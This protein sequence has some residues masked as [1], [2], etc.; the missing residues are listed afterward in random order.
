MLDALFALRE[1]SEYTESA[2]LQVRTKLAA[3][4]IRQHRKLTPHPPDFEQIFGYLKVQPT[5][6][7]L[8]YQELYRRPLFLNYVPLL[9]EEEANKYMDSSEA[10]LTDAMLYFLRSTGVLQLRRL[11]G[12]LAVNREDWERYRNRSNGKASLAGAVGMLDISIP[13]G[14]KLIRQGILPA[15]KVQTGKTYHYEIAIE[16]IEALKPKLEWANL[17]KIAKSYERSREHTRQILGQHTLSA[18]ISKRRNGKKNR[19]HWKRIRKP[20]E[21]LVRLLDFEQH[22]SKQ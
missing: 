2:P 6:V 9:R 18:H 4:I 20:H 14:R 19:T 15:T 17:S 1:L 10:R 11:N 3:E 7:A 12:S 21:V 16:D 5:D 22:F 8:T 13:Y